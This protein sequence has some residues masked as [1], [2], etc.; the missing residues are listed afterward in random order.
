MQ[1]VTFMRLIHAAA[2]YKT[3]GFQTPTSS[4]DVLYTA[5]VTF[6]EVLE[7]LAL[8]LVTG[9]VGGFLGIGGSIIIIPLLT[10]L[11][12]LNQHL[13]QAVAMII[14]V[15]VALPALLQHHRAK[16]VRWDVMH[17]MLPFG[18]VAIIVGVE[19]SNRVDET[20]L[21][22]C[23]AVFLLYMIINNIMQLVKKKR[24]SEAH[25]QHVGWLPVGFIGTVTGF[26][27][28]LLGIGGGNI[29]IPLLQRIANLPLRQCIAT[30][31]AFM[32][33]SASVGAIRKNMSLAQLTDSTGVS[34]GLTW[35]ESV[36]IASVL[37]PTAVVGGLI[38][39]RLTHLLPL[40]WIRA[41]F[42]LLLTWACL[43]MFDVL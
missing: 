41:A 35:Q 15:F 18:L 13:S 9:I 19:S 8:G 25:Q 39:G 31:A 33:V 40:N 21:K 5:A 22:Q 26:M 34:L 14:N 16:A 20:L 1:R 2:K 23:F 6:V 12:H 28:G 4:P 42:I 27:A 30:T 3:R 29:A 7:L 37:A 32:C 43:D 36:T 24:E 11:L 10:L 17:R 38:G